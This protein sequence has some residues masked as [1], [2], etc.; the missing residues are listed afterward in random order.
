MKYNCLT[1]LLATS[2]FAGILSTAPTQAQAADSVV[3]NRLTKIDEKVGSGKEALPGNTVFVHYTGWLHDPFASRER[4]N[5]FDSSVGQ[6]AFSF[7]IG[8][9]RVIKGWEQGVAG[10]KVGGKRTLIIPPEL[11]YGAA[12]AGNGMIPPNAYLIFDI[13]L[14]DVK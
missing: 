2:L 13:E 3:I 1:A 8:S 11:G 12:G 5:K 7:T 6:Q 10:M 14:L 9:G 4:G